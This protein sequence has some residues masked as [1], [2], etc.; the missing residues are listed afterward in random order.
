MR[1]DASRH[2]WKS[3]RRRRR[4]AKKHARHPL[5]Q[6]TNRTRSAFCPDIPSL[7][8]RSQIELAADSRF[9]QPVNLYFGRRDRRAAQLK[10]L[11][12]RARTMQ[13]MWEAGMR[14]NIR[15][16]MTSG[17]PER[18]NNGKYCFSVRYS[19]ISSEKLTN[20]QKCLRLGE[21]SRYLLPWDIKFQQNYLNSSNSS[22]LIQ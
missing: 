11:Q 1:R 9:C 6:K 2:R 21:V 4:R 19:I 14:R 13:N 17:V 20:M 5:S 10:L 16:V 15:N 7:S 22:E 3:R 8:L 12:K 18:K